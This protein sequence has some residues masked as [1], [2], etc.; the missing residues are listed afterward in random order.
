MTISTTKRL[1]KLRELYILAVLF[2]LLLAPAGA[3]PTSILSLRFGDLRIVLI[4][5]PAGGPYRLLIRFT[6]AFIK[7]YLEVKD[8]YVPSAV[9]GLQQA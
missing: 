6:L 8:A 3:Q 5:D 4:K 9:R 1:F 7:T 2:L